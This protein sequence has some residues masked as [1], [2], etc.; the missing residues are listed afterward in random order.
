M[1]DSQMLVRPRL[2]Y[3]IERAANQREQWNSNSRRL[4]AALVARFNSPA[5]TPPMLPK[6]AMKV[7][8]ISRREDVEIDEILSVLEQD[9]LLA[10]RIL[11]LVHMPEYRP[12]EP[13]RSLRDAVVRLGINRVRDFV[14]TEILQLRLFHSSP[15]RV[16]ME[17]LS[18]HSLA[19]A[20]IAEIIAE[21]VDG[22][23]PDEAFLCGLMHDMGLAGL[24]L[25]ASEEPRTRRLLTPD[26]AAPVLDALH[27]GA[28]AIIGMM[29]RLPEKVR[30]VMSAHHYANPGH[31]YYALCATV[32]LADNLAERAG[33]GVLPHTEDDSGL[34]RSLE[35]ILR[36]AEFF[37]GFDDVDIQSFR[38][39]AYDI[40]TDLKRRN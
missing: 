2:A 5:Y 20:Q 11:R 33:A 16:V 3:P 27:A 25:A 4:A 39:D 17:R 7:I 13:I 24:I 30:A 1:P 22:L 28:G 10:G 34:D 19:V 37:L 40:V 14:V 15:L 23:D 9:N 8:E 29:W 12:I 26:D 6:V 18:T 32:M 36:E 31:E 38:A 21:R 35:V